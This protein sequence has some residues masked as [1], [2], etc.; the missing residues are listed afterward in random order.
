MMMP[1]WLLLGY[2]SRN[3]IIAMVGTIGSALLADHPSILAVET[4]LR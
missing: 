2:G 3:C 4:E 1:P